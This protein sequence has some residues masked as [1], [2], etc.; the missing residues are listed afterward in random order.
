MNHEPGRTHEAS[1]VEAYRLGRD[2][3]VMPIGMVEEHCVPI[4]AGPVTFVVEA[5]SLSQEAIVANEDRQAASDGLDHDYDVDAAGASLHVLG[6]DDGLEYLRFD[7]FDTEPHYHYIHNDLQQNTVVRVDDVAEGDPLT[8]TLRVVG[9]R[10]PEMLAHA[11]A[12]ELAEAVRARADEVA[13]GFAQ[14][15]PLLR[16]AED[17]AQALR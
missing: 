7:A 16:Q 6:A 9:T 13:T 4:P 8:W 2:Y 12:P 10:L 14:L 15:E 11:R 1:G 17:Q 3:T 5:R